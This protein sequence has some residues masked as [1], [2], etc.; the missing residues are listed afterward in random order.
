MIQQNIL[1]FQKLNITQWHESNYAGKHSTIVV[2]DV[3]GKPHPF[4]NVIEPIPTSFTKIDHKTNVCSV[5]R[6]IAPEATIYA[7]QWSAAIKPQVI[8]W[9]R[10]HEKEIDVINFSVG[11]T[12]V[13]SE[14]YKLKEFDIPII[15][16]AGN[17][18]R[19]TS[20]SPYG[21]LPWVL[22]VGAWLEYN[23]KKAVYSNAG[24]ELDIVAY[25]NIYIPTSDGYDRVMMFTGTSCAAPVVSGMIALYNGWR[26]ERGLPKMTRAEAYTFVKNNTLDKMED[27]HDFSSGHGLFVMPN[28]EDI[29][30]NI[31]SPVEPELPINDPS[32]PTVEDPVETPDPKPPILEEPKQDDI[33]FFTVQ[34]TWD[35]V[36][37]SIGKFINMQQAILFAQQHPGYNVYDAT[38]YTVW[39][40]PLPEPEPEPEPEVNLNLIY[41]LLLQ[42]MEFLKNLFSK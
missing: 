8:E 30:I 35:N 21:N 10:E 42:I 15:V 33:W 26:K 4:T 13:N 16:A 1:E 34:L 23:D 18:E 19:D 29:V 41:K 37:S 25:T 5:A 2:L 27:G 6:E 24:P 11:G 38:G 14:F 32:E 36:Q 12:T 39:R 31:P 40:N 22:S 28:L 20:L 7:F 9:I 3:A 17:D